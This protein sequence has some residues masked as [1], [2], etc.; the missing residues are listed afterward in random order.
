MMGSLQRW[1]IF[2]KSTLLNMW[3]PAIQWNHETLKLLHHIKT[4]HLALK[5]K[6]LEFF[7][8][9]KCEHEDLKQ[10]LKA[11]TSSNVSAL[12]ASFL[13]ANCIAKTKKLF[14]VGEELI[15]PAAMDIC[16]ELLRETAVLKVACVPLWA[17]SLTR[18][19][20]EITE[21]IQ[22]QL[23]GLVSHHGM[24]SRLTSPPM[25]TTR[26]RF[27]FLCYVFRR[28]CRRICYVHSCCQPTLQPQSYSSLWLYIRKTELV[29]LC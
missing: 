25:L 26:Q 2:S 24:Q 21:D 6:T 15:L 16:R 23:L 14:T 12:R 28:I 5:H 19:L 22:A 11:T 29:I 8:R 17:S 10:L 27:L 20:D 1:F 3:W 4:K 7:K 18:R 9:K 13:V